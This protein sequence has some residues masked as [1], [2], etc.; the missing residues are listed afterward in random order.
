[1]GRSWKSDETEQMAQTSNKQSRQVNKSDESCGHTD[2]ELI[3]QQHRKQHFK[4]L[5]KLC[6]L[7]KKEFKTYVYR[8]IISN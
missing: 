6:K 8:K 2:L 7:R 1:M 3:R 4:I 5:T